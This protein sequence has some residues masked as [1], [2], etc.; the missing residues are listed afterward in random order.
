MFEI[1]EKGYVNNIKVRS[2]H[3]KLSNISTLIIEQLPQFK[4]AKQKN[5]NVSIKYTLPI[6]FNLEE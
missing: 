5:K 4:P 2:P 3:S 1:N 6:I